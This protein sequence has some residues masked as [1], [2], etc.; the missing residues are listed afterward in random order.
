[1]ITVRIGSDEKDMSSAIDEHW[2]NQ[3]LNRRRRDGETVC[4]RVTIRDADLQM[5]LSTPSCGVGA[6]GGRAPT[7]AEQEI[8][9]S[10]AHRGLNQPDFTGGNLI[11]FLK[12]LRSL[13]GS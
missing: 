12:Q 4:V 1:M 9:D 8:F 3:E 13:V 2:I 11:A 10:W 7:A 5:V 6:G